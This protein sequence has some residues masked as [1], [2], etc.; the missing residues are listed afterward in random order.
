[1]S[2]VK[3]YNDIETTDAKLVKR[4]FIYL[5]S[6]KA[7]MSMGIHL[8][9]NVKTKI[10]NLPEIQKYYI[11]KRKGKATAEGHPPVG[12]VAPAEVRVAE[13]KG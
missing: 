2:L 1:M 12:P 8:R 7:T 4:K 5:Q 13:E 9:I 11:Q 10:Y 3:R 6:K